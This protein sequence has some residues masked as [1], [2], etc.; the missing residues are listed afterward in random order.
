MSPL[1][2]PTKIAHLYKD[3]LQTQVGLKGGFFCYL[4][5]WSLF[6]LISLL[7]Q[8]YV[9][10]TDFVLLSRSLEKPFRTGMNSSADDDVSQ[11]Y[12]L[13]SIDEDFDKSNAR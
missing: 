8:K 12:P 1:T 5:R 6:S 11:I 4:R 13:L 9:L 3:G 10:L 2:N 7:S